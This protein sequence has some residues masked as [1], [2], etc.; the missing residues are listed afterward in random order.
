[1]SNTT[2]QANIDCALFDDF[3]LIVLGSM[4]HECRHLFFTAAAIKNRAGLRLFGVDQRFCNRSARPELVLVLEI[5][6]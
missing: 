4:T 6:G 2:L 5:L 1:M 3:G